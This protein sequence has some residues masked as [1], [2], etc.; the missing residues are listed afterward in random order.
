[1]G[2]KFKNQ[3]VVT[4]N[5]IGINPLQVPLI[6]FSKKRAK[7]TKGLGDEP[8]DF[9]AYF[10]TRG[11]T[12]QHIEKIRRVSKGGSL[13]AFYDHCKATP[14]LMDN[15]GFTAN[16]MTRIMSI[17]GGI[18][19]LVTVFAYIEVLNR[20]CGG[21][22][23]KIVTLASHTGA[24]CSIEA[25]CSP[26]Q[27]EL[28]T[29]HGFDIA[30]IVELVS[31][32]GG[33]RKL[34]LVHMYAARLLILRVTHDT[35][36]NTVRSAGSAESAEIA[37][38]GIFATARNEEIQRNIAVVNNIL[39]QPLVLPPALVVAQPMML[40][41]PPVV[42]V[43]PPKTQVSY[44]E[45]DMTEELPNQSIANFSFDT[46]LAINNEAS[47]RV[48]ASTQLYTN[49]WGLNRNNVQREE[50]VDFERFL[51]LGPEFK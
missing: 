25:L 13:K 8:N 45:F 9:D 15:H 33:K 20:Y 29:T 19:N 5:P 47:T 6:Q 50:D 3:T 34:E 18:H 2:K 16:D 7:Y 38:R 27:N 48:Q 49:Q 42:V 17:Q 12:A 36:I 44:L 21:E 1:M 10:T 43:E 41:H 23:D 14:N 22:K 26:M 31:R 28:T 35:I 24:S 32:V 37:L 11:F 30:Q 51:N 46:I 39:Q 4:P 40:A